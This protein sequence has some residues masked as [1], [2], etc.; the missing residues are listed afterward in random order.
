[1]SWVPNTNHYTFLNSKSF[2][3]PDIAPSPKNVFMVE[4]IPTT[5]S[6]VEVP[7]SRDLSEDAKLDDLTPRDP[8]GMFQSLTVAAAHV[9]TS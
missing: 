8:L 9:M 3:R 1:M 4:E 7:K 2:K 5:A 6:I